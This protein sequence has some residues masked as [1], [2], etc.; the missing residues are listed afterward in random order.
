MITS[1]SDAHA[2]RRAIARALYERILHLYRLNHHRQ[3]CSSQHCIQL[4]PLEQ[5]AQAASTHDD[6]VHVLTESFMRLKVLKWN[7]QD[8]DLVH[9]EAGMIGDAELF[10]DCAVLQAQ[11]NACRQQLEAFSRFV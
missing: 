3:V 9:T 5:S 8:L 6:L 4:P 7:I 2:A 10:N 1:T 11:H